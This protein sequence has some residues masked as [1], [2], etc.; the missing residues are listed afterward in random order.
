MLVNKT[1]DAR[2]LSLNKLFLSCSLFLV[3]YGVNM[4]WIWCASSINQ[5]FYRHRHHSFF[6]RFLFKIRKFWVCV[7]LEDNRIL[8]NFHFLGKWLSGAGSF[9]FFYKHFSRVI[10]Y[11]NAIDIFSYKSFAYIAFLDKNNLTLPN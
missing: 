3:K 11:D 2:F 8:D 1:F 5:S 10:N 4:V 9:W 7:D 6:V